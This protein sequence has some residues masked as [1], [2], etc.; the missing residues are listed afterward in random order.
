MGFTPNRPEIN[1]QGKLVGWKNATKNFTE[2]LNESTGAG[3]V[4]DTVSLPE[5]QY[6]ALDYHQYNQAISFR[7]LETGE[8]WFARIHPFTQ[9]FRI[10]NPKGSYSGICSE[11]ILEKNDPTVV[12]V[13]EI[14]Q[15]TLLNVNPSGGAYPRWSSFTTTSD[16]GAYLTA[17]DIFL[18]SEANIYNGTKSPEGGQ[19]A[20]R[21]DGIFV[22]V[23]F[24]DTDSNGTYEEECLIEI[25]R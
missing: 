3:L 12:S 1:Q 10:G 5:T 17:S 4:R 11:L 15:A 23:V 7:G 18:Q 20:V 2:N 25:C 8:D 21:K 6:V 24:V 19:L 22:K 14:A 16:A 13:S 9:D